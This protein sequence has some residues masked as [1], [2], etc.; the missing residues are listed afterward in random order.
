[1]ADARPDVTAVLVAGWPAAAFAVAVELLLQQRRAE[2]HDTDTVTGPLPPAPTPEPLPV[3]HR[4]LPYPPV[5]APPAHPLSQVLPVPAVDPVTATSTAPAQTPPGQAPESS[6][7]SPPTSST[8]GDEDLVARVRALLGESAGQTLGRRT[9]A[10]RL[11]VSEHQARLALD[12]VGATAGP[13]LNGTAARSKTA[14]SDQ[15]AQ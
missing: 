5:T 15:G 14:T 3:L 9:V 2:R 6:R 8:G 7:V 12:L 4:P 10:K 1:M 11:G 13:A